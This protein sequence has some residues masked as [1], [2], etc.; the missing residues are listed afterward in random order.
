MTSARRSAT[1]LL[2]GASLILALSLGIRHGFGLF[3]PPM[4]S[5]FG[6]GREVFAFAIALQNLVTNALKFARQGVPPAV[7]IS[8]ME[9]AGFLAL[10]VTDNGIGIPPEHLE[11]L[12]QPFFSTKIG[13]GGTGLGMAIARSVMEGHGGHLAVERVH[14]EGGARVTLWWPR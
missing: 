3:L 10:R 9:S 14:P 5:E 13:K 4:S 1:W 2:L 7:H 12:F 8:A 6:W 11:K